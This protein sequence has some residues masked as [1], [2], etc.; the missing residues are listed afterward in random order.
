M[1]EKSLETFETLALTSFTSIPVALPEIDKK[2]LRADQKYLLGISKAVSTGVCPPDL[3][4]RS[5]GTMSHSRWLTTA[6]AILHLYVSIA[7]PP[8]F[9]KLFV[10]LL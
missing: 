9:F 8:E 7:E 5:P 2:D 3:A 1:K 10:E 6:N 4:N